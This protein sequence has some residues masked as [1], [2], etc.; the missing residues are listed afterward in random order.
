[1]SSDL[2]D[3]PRATRPLL[4]GIQE[5]DE[6]DESL[7]VPIQDCSSINNPRVEIVGGSHLRLQNA[8]EDK[9]NFCYIV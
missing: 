1:M 9:Y 7:V 2:E 5:V 8:P 3:S 4:H 6:E